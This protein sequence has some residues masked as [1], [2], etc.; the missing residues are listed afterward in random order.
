M[1]QNIV[2]TPSAGPETHSNQ[3]QGVASPYFS[4]KSLGPLQSSLT[5]DVE[6]CCTRSPITEFGVASPD[7]FLESTT[8]SPTTKKGV[9]A[10]AS[11]CVS[12]KSAVA[13]VKRTGFEAAASPSALVKS[14]S[15][16]VIAKSGIVPVALTSDRYSSFFLQ[17]NAVVNDCNQA[18]T[19]KLL[20][21]TPTS[22]QVEDQ[23]HVKAETQMAKKPIDRL[24]AAVSLEYCSAS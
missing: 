12:V 15:P 18:T 9:V 14:A 22:G 21:P 11:P 6:L 8:Q 19:T 2:T 7:V 23:E 20:T 4:Q 10:A 3:L 16:L 1:R 13:L 5:N 24:I 17:N